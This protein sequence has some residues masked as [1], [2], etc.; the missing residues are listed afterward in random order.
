[1]ATDFTVAESLSLQREAS[2]RMGS[3]LYARILAG[4]EADYAAGGLTAEL[5]DGRTDR[6]VHDA[7]PLRL[8]G[9]VHRIVLAGQAPDLA[10]FY[11]SA[12]GTAQGDPSAEFLRVVDAHRASVDGALDRGVQTNEVGRAAVLAPGFALIARRSGLPLRLRE[13]GSSAGLLL[14]WDRYR[15]IADGREMGDP[16]SPLVFD[17]AWIPPEPDLGGVVEVLD[18]RGCDIAPIDATTAEGRLTLLSFIWPDQ[19]E[20]LTRL[21]TALDLAASNPVTIDAADA[22]PWVEEAVAAPPAGAVTV[23]FHSIVLQYLPSL[24]RRRM[25]SAL[26]QAGAA[27]TDDAPLA[28]LRMEPAGMEAA[29]LRLTSW[30]GGAEEVLATT[31]FHGRDIAWPPQARSSS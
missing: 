2:A 14:R 22:G 4:V 8:L 27:A 21:R 13:V 17:D 5:L 26:E 3:V 30:P 1:V 29:D 28:W 11:P 15:Y 24:S 10:R 6:P 31:G 20:R 16:D 12:G 18:R 9:A 25:R 7:L 23:V 19:A